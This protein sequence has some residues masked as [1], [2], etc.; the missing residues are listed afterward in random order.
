MLPLEP[1]DWQT[2]RLHSAFAHEHE[3][4]DDMSSDSDADWNQASLHPNE[5]FVQAQATSDRDIDRTQVTYHEFARRTVNPDTWDDDSDLD[6]GDDSDVE[7]PERPT[8][9]DDIQDAQ[10]YRMRDD[11]PIELMNCWTAAGQVRFN[12]KMDQKRLMKVLTRPKGTAFLQLP[13]KLFREVA[14]HLDDGDYLNLCTALLVARGRGHSNPPHTRDAPA[15]SAPRDEAEA[16][17]GWKKVERKKRRRPSGRTAAQSAGK[18]VPSWAQVAGDGAV[19]FNFYIG[20][21]AGIA[22]SHTARKPWGGSKKKE[23]KKEKGKGK[24]Q[25]APRV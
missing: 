25:R 14:E 23:N 16:K 2:V 22:K 4:D 24:E 3:N 13:A 20:G 11:D 19:C 5:R 10:A 18:S 9:D 7:L 12:A 15:P 21:G 8:W 1:R 6:A 17:E